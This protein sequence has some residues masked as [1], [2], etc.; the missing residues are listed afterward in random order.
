MKKFKES[1]GGFLIEILSGDD[2]LALFTLSNAENNFLELG[3]ICK[4]KFIAQRDLYSAALALYYT[5]EEKAV[6]M[7]QFQKDWPDLDTVL[8]NAMLTLMNTQV[9]GQKVPE[10]LIPNQIEKRVSIHTSLRVPEQT[11]CC[12][13][14]N[15][16]SGMD[17]NPR[18]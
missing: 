3:D 6:N 15:Q 5:Q 7:F 16:N 2:L 8:K 10:S 18:P 1:R 4:V 17:K 12:T 13:I 14:R 9:A 11:E